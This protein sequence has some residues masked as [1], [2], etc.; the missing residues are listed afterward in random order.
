[1]ERRPRSK[2]KKSNPKR[3]DKT[4]HDK[5]KKPSKTKNKEDVRRK[6]TK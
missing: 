5:T 3:K 6:G 2:D 4:L 1:M